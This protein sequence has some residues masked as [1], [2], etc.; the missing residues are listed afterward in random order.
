MEGSREE[1][2]KGNKEEK[3]QDRKGAGKEAAAAR[4]A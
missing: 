1:P 2:R 3:D 4:G